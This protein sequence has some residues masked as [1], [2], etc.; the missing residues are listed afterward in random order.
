MRNAAVLL[1]LLIAACSSLP[2]TDESVLATVN[3]EVITA[4]EFRLNYEFGHG[5]LRQGKTPREDYLRFLILEQVMAHEAQRMRLGTSAAVIHA[6]HTLR[7]E[8]LIE[9]VFEEHVLA[10][11]E[12]T[13][14]EITAAINE[15]AVRFQFRFLPARSRAE[16]SAAARADQISRL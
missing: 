11:I 10:D 6:M 5:H 2:D 9:R 1:L 4:D 3:G 8:L 16:A 7:E 12:V 13:Q 14:A 15:N